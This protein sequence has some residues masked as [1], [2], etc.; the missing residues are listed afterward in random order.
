MNSYEFLKPV[1]RAREPCLAMVYL[2]QL[3]NHDLTQAMLSASKFQSPYHRNNVT[4][5]KHRMVRHPK[6]KELF[7]KKN[8]QLFLNDILRLECSM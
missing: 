1:H 7:K 4:V 5:E 8:L 2:N 6:G 3:N